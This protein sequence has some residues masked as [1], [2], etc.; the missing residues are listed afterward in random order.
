MSSP[1][2]LPEAAIAHPS[3]RWLIKVLAAHALI[4]SA[5]I[6][7]L[8]IGVVMMAGGMCNGCR[9]GVGDAAGLLSG[10]GLLL[11]LVAAIVQ[12]TPSIGF[13]FLYRFVDQPPHHFRPLAITLLAAYLLWPAWVLLWLGLV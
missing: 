8:A 11:G 2:P 13:Y 3:Y 6:Y 4:I 1:P 5:G 12:S 10:W 7:L 9:V